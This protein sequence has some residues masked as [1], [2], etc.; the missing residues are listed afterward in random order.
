M[1]QS[2]TV[3]V[4]NAIA[5]LAGLAAAKVAAA[6]NKTITLSGDASGSGTSGITVTLDTVNSDV[7]TF[8]GITVNG[9][10]LV[11]AAVAAA[12]KVHL[13]TKRSQPPLASRPLAP[14]L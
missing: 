1:S 6:P 4:Q 12:T 7:G 13:Q 2:P 14:L 8:Q 3:V 5:Q 11:T 10:G 9:K